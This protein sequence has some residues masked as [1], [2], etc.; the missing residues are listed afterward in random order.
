MFHPL[1]TPV[2]REA[3]WILLDPGQTCTDQTMNTCIQRPGVKAGELKDPTGEL[4]II[5]VKT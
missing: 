4:K 1:T 2:N 3:L 5:M